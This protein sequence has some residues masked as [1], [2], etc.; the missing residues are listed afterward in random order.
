MNIEDRLRTELGTRADELTAPHVEVSG[1]ERLGRQERRRRRTA[2]GSAGAAVAAAVV[3]SSV[4]LI[5]QPDGSSGPEPAPAPP[6]V[7]PSVAPSEPPPIPFIT[8]GTLHMGEQSI[9]IDPTWQL[10][11]ANG[12]TLVGRQWEGPWAVVGDDR[13]WLVQLPT[14][15]TTPVGVILSDDGSLAAWVNTVDRTTARVVLW[16]LGAGEEVDRVEV[17]VGAGFGDRLALNGI[18]REGRLTWTTN[19]LEDLTLWRPG[20]DPVLV[21]GLPGTHDRAWP[22]GVVA[23][24]MLGE[25]S[26]QGRFTALTRI[27]DPEGAS[28]LWSPDGTMRVRADGTSVVVENYRTTE[29]TE[30]PALG[31]LL[32][33]VAPRAWI[34]PTQVVLSGPL[35][36]TEAQALILCDVTEILCEPIVEDLS[37]DANLPDR[38]W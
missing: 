7:V 21:T 25:I 14:G 13:P 34:S 38:W 4:S 11:H 29:E 26:D 9:P 23:G 18:D 19:D 27:E 33:N 17:T 15:T 37:N 16:D 22:G 1:L 36:A 32:R 28:S 20:S 2:L 35:A 5:A 31:V 3:I 6:S 10:A 30:F 8:A 24:G 12:T